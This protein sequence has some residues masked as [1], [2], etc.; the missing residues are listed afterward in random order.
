MVTSVKVNNGL[1]QLLG[2]TLFT[3][4][5]T[6]LIAG[7]VLYEPLISKENMNTTMSN[8][9]GHIGSIYGS[10]L[11]QMLT[12]LVIIILGIAMYLTAGHMNKAM[13]MIALSFYLLEAA[14]I[15]VSQ[16]FVFGLVR[17]SQL[18]MSSG[19]A[20]LDS[21][22]KVLL[23]CRDFSAKMAIIPF[24]LGALLFYYLLMKAQIIPKWLAVWGI[25]T[26]PFVLIGVPLMAFGM[27]V[28]FALFV[29]YVPFEFV[30]GIYI[31]IRYRRQQK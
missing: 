26:V 16:V 18:S 2:I 30:T 29:P 11:L 27:K 9:T 13:A 15:V 31:I 19:D 23:I 22:A 1:Y 28:P 6:S 12:A 3:Q 4:A 25:A 7:A 10:V 8:L 14:L 17:V 21:L 24:G 20:G 5:L